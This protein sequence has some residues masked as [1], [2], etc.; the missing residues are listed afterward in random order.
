MKGIRI[1][2]RHACHFGAAGH[3][4]DVELDVARKLIK[5]GYAWRFEGPLPGT[6]GDRPRPARTTGPAKPAA[7][8]RGKAGAFE[9]AV[10]DD[11]SEYADGEAGRKP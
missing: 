3:V 7:G 11:E 9:R 1:K 8:P 2:L 10:L 4:L 6:E 5:A